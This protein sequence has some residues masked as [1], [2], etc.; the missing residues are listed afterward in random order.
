MRSERGI[1]GLETA[2]I[3]IA[4]VVVASVFAFTILSSGIFASE[5][6]KETVYAGVEETQ[7][8]VHPTGGIIALS[9]PVSTTTAVNRVKFTLSLAN[10]ADAVEL[11]PSYTA[12]T[13][14]V[15]PV[16]SGVTG[17]TIVSYTDT[18]QHLSET[19]WT[20]AWLGNSDGDNLLE[21]NETAEITVWL[22]PRAADDSFSLSTSTTVYM[23]HRLTANGKFSLEVSPPVGSSFDLQRMLP[24]QLDT[25]LLLD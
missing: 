24:P 9:G 8:T 21:G 7:T 17:P 22:H 14:G 3:L 1:T 2:I 13:T 16:A 4:F 12:G 5:R 25:A 18:T 11:T 15:A 23:D 10:D 20:L 6:A 19:R